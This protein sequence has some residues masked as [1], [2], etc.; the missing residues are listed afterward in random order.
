MRVW[1]TIIVR[2]IINAVRH[3]LWLLFRA[4]KLQMVKRFKKYIYF[5]MAIRYSGWPSISQKSFE[6]LLNND[7]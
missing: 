7:E 6:K 5:G 3:A 1:P 4:P 2:R